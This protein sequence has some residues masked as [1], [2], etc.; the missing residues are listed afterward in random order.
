MHIVGGKNVAEELYFQA[1][2]PY[3]VYAEIYGGSVTRG[4]KRNRT[5]VLKKAIFSNFGRLSLERLEIR[6]IILHSDLTYLTGFPMS[7]KCVTLSDLKCHFM[8]KSVFCVG[9]T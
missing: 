5:K 3:K 1:D 4:L 9:L 2:K 6:L 7:L 8:L